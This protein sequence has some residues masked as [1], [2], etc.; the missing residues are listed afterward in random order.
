MTK[1]FPPPTLSLIPENAPFSAEQRTWLSGFFAGLISADGTVV[2]GS[3]TPVSP[4]DRQRIDARC[5]RG[6][7]RR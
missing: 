6:G 2:D 4:E 5:A 3:V 7:R 1:N